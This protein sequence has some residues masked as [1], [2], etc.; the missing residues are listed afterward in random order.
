MYYNCPS[1]E[2]I[3]S[4][5]VVIYDNDD[6]ITADC[7]AGCENIKYIDGELYM[8]ELNEYTA[9]YNIPQEWGGSLSF[10]SFLNGFEISSELLTDATISFEGIVGDCITNWG[11]GAIN[12]DTTHTYSREGRFIIRTEIPNPL[13]L[14]TGSPASADKTHCITKIFKLHTSI[15]TN[16]NYLLAGFDSLYRIYDLTFDNTANGSHMLDGC[17]K[18]AVFNAENWNIGGTDL[19]YMFNNCP[20]ITHVS[21]NIPDNIKN[22][23]YMFNGCTGLRDISGSR[24]GAGIT[25]TTDWIP[26][27]QILYANNISLNSQKINFKNFN[28]LTQ[29]NNLMINPSFTNLNEL[30][31]GCSSIM[32]IDLS[33]NSLLNCRGVARLCES[34]TSLLSL[35]LPEFSDKVDIY[36]LC[37]GCSKVEVIEF[38]PKIMDVSRQYGFTDVNYQVF[39]NCSH[40]TTIKN[41][42]VKCTLLDSDRE[43]YLSRQNLDG[44]QYMWGGTNNLKNTEGMGIYN[45]DGR[46]IFYGYRGNISEFEI[47]SEVTDVSYLFAEAS[48]ITKLDLSSWD[49]E[50]V[51]NLTYLVQKCSNLTSFIPP[52]NISVSLSDFTK[53]TSIAVGDLVSIINNLSN[54]SSTQTLTLGSTNLA[55]LTPQQVKIATD[56]G[57]TVV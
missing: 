49:A 29:C 26:K 46:A 54:V 50:N 27:S 9:I 18:L 37:A 41:F 30:F 56:K 8:N 5:W 31:Y 15:L 17:T 36:R 45:N 44:V 39:T 4:N 25:T 11:D 47:G 52:M 53:A 20:S 43:K 12:R 23:S 1:L 28:K 7:Y 22:I 42:K 3:T 19:S 6:M 40:L 57:W 38:Y 32:N 21:I 2:S 13:G 35:K 48:G 34:C 24:F 10:D 55:K 51:K 14:G 16:G 33:N